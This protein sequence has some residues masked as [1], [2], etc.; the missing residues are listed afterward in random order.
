[1]GM[2]VTIEIAA[3]EA[4]QRS[5]DEVFDYL[6]YIDGKFSTY[7]ET[8]EIS[9]INRGEIE[10]SKWSEDMNEVFTLS[11]ETKRLTGGYFDIVARNGKYDPS[12]LVKGWAIKNAADILRGRGTE[13]FYIEIAGDIETS[14]KNSKNEPWRIGIQNPLS[15]REEIVK[16]LSVTGAGV[17]TSG[18]A[19]QKQHIYNPFDKEVLLDEIVSLTVIG[20]NIYEADRFATAAFAMG[21]AGIEFI[22]RLEGFEG[23][24]I[25]RNGIAIMTSG[26]NNYTVQPNA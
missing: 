23:Y 11:E 6:V 3:K 19:I 25:D 9:A 8:S 22:E 17:A 10:E 1:M 20:P 16:T 26:F 2:A 7:K 24:Q 13:N 4:K 5:F 18:T 21:R 14:G 15:K 12:G